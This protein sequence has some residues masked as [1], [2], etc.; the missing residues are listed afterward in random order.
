MKMT[1]NDRIFRMFK[2]EDLS[3]EAKAIYYYMHAMNGGADVVEVDRDTLCN[4]LGISKARFYRHRA[5]L[6]SRGFIE[7][8]DNKFTTPVYI[9]K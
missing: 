5:Y 4:D 1:L 2:A 9:L 8:L 6:I 7:V 3:I